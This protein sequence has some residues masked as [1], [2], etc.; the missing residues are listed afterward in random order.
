MLGATSSATRAPRLRPGGSRRRGA[1]PGCSSISPRAGPARR[2]WRSPG[3]NGRATPGGAGGRPSSGGGRRSGASVA[4][5]RGVAGAWKQRTM[6]K[7]L[8]AHAKA[9]VAEVA[10]PSTSTGQ[11]GGSPREMA[12]GRVPSLSS[13]FFGYS[14]NFGNKKKNE[15]VTVAEVVAGVAG[16]RSARALGGGRTS[17]ITSAIRRGLPRAAVAHASLARQTGREISS[18]PV[19]APEPLGIPGPGAARPHIRTVGRTVPR[20]EV[21]RWP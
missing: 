13:L 11:R 2:R 10:A 7:F 19:H 9:G 4:G 1:G 17:D 8:D 18:L 5:A 20:R 16:P 14:G 12:G 6:R 21:S 15:G 3:W